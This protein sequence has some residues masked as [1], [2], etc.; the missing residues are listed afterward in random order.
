[1]RLSSD[2]SVQ[3]DDLTHSALASHGLHLLPIH[4]AYFRERLCSIL[5][6]AITAVGSG[7]LLLVEPCPTETQG[8]ETLQER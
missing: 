3:P 1:M 2:H 7:N 6:R 8:T 5:M 4:S